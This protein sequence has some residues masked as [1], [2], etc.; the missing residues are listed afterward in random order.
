MTARQYLE[1]FRVRWRIVLSGLAL[2]LAVGVGVTWYTPTMYEADVT[3]LIG[4]RQT[5]GDSPTDLSQQRLSTYAALLTSNKILSDVAD[6]LRPSITP[7]ELAGKIRAELK[8]ETVLLK[9]IASDSSPGRAVDIASVVATQFVQSVAQIERPAGYD[10]PLITG[11]LF[12]SSTPSVSAVSPKP[13]FNLALGAGLGALIG[14]GLALWRHSVDPRIRSRRALE[15]IIDVPVLGAVD[16]SVDLEGRALGTAAG[17]VAG[18]LAAAVDEYRTLRTYLRFGAESD[19]NQVLVVAGV[20]PDCDAAGA[21]CNLAVV[22]GATGKR[23]V[24]VDADIRRPMVADRFG[25]GAGAGLSELLTGGLRPGQALRRAGPAGV[26]VVTSG[27]EPAGSSELLSSPRMRAL[28][29]ELRASHDVVL[30]VAPPLTALPDAAAVVSHGD[31]VVLIVRQKRSTT[32]Q[33][34]AATG[35]LRTIEA[36]CVGAVLTPAR[37][38]RKGKAS[39][40]PGDDAPSMPVPGLVPQPADRWQPGVAAT[41]TTPTVALPIDRTVELDTAGST[42][43][44]V[45]TGSTSHDQDTTA[46]ERNAGVNGATVVTIA[47]SKEVGADQQAQNGDDEASRKRP[48]PSP[49]PR[50]SSGDRG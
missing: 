24:V 33:V 16:P 22:V 35:A 6:R 44:P 4:V 34:V 21:A 8:P 47:P 32:P 46:P 39:T 20:A 11:Q 50:A 1:I 41:A 36:R 37:S 14:A 13:E 43:G 25:I 10:Q 48:T 40:R 9:V 29:D 15:D 23:V 42:G 3:V 5:P 45:P 18:K 7:S 2:G 19:Q 30:I 27:P 28:I 31:G 17:K 49:R 26:A 12:E 38:S